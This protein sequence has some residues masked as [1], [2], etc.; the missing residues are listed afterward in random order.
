M[1]RLVLVKWGR[2]NATTRAIGLDELNRKVPRQDVPNSGNHRA[3]RDC[4]LPLIGLLILK[5]MKSIY[6]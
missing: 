2:P 5:Y 3:A 4:Q 1:F 6:Q